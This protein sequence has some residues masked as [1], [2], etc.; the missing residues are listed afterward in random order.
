MLEYHIFTDMNEN[1]QQAYV[2]VVDRGEEHISVMDMYTIMIQHRA[3]EVKS[4]MNMAELQRLITSTP[5]GN[6]HTKDAKTI[7]EVFGEL[8]PMEIRLQHKEEEIEKELFDM[9]TDMLLRAAEAAE[10]AHK[11]P[12]DE[13]GTIILTNNTS[14]S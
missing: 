8:I 4:R 2:F 14:K 5:G 7:F 10:S 13:N 3:G 12:L 1:Y 11:T 6:I 9:E